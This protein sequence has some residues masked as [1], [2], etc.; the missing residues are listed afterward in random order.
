MDGSELLRGGGGLLAVLG[1]LWLFTK[2]LRTRAGVDAPELAT[3][4][5]R[6]VQRAT[7]GR[8]SSVVTVDAGDRVLVLGVTDTGISVLAEQPAL[9]APDR[10]TARTE[11]V[12]PQPRGTEPTGPDLLDLTQPSPS[13]VR[14]ASL[15]TGSWQAAVA[16]AREWTVR[17]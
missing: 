11:V 1:T 9:P 16:T 5:L 12:L 6:V 17:R 3:R 2:V 14:P 7:L 10:V 13:R 15:R 4:R 8:R